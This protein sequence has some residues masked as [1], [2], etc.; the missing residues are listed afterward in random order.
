MF[1]TP[2][3][4]LFLIIFLFSAGCSDSNLAETGD[5]SY[6]PYFWK[7]E[8]NKKTSYLLGTIHEGVTVEHLSCSKKIKSYLEESDYFF[9]EVYLEPNNKGNAS[10]WGNDFSKATYLELNDQSNTTKGSNN[11]SWIA[12]RESKNLGDD[13]NP[14]DKQAN[15]RDTNGRD[16]NGQ[17]NQERIDFTKAMLSKENGREFKSLSEESKIFLRSRDIPENLNYSGYFFTVL[18]LCDQSAVFRA[19]GEGVSL[20]LQLKAMAQ[21]KG[22]PIEYLD[23]G[24]DTE[25]IDQMFVSITV[26]ALGGE[27]DN[28]VVDKQILNF[29]KCVADQMVS[30]NQY[31]T[32]DISVISGLS[33]D[34]QEIILKERNLIWLD[35]LKE[36]RQKYN[37]VFLAGGVGHFIWEFN[38]LD[39]LRNEGF[40]VHRMNSSCSF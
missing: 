12:Y 28:Q 11:F 33:L 2:K 34:E 5:K 8:K 16:T 36:S 26:S 7:V 37:H 35:K 4:L 13:D 15:G 19:G 31:K 22:M 10:Q 17:E 32:G 1:L 14:P 20:D 38:I 25:R 23:A 9:T 27:V 40:S 21:S 18:F 3:I 6:A 39:M 29:E 30:F 24:I